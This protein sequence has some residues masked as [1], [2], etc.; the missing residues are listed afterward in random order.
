MAT[1]LGSLTLDLICRTGNFTQGMRDAS[2]SATREMGRIEQSTNNVTNAL[3]GM[4]VAAIGTFSLS[5]LSGYADEYIN[6]QNRL[7]LVTSSQ[8]E[9]AQ[10]TEDTYR[11]SQ[12]TASSWDSTAQV[13]QRF[14]QNAKS[15]GI[16]LKQAASLTETDVGLGF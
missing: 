2:N 1:K 16:N 4:A 15:L 9:L 5:Q 3:K 14:A 13:Y 12:V 7:K 6:L 11:I 10:A 8:K